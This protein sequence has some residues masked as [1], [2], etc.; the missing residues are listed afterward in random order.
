[1]E[2][3]L[4]AQIEI[5]AALQIIDREIREHAAVKQGLLGELQEKQRLIQERKQNYKIIEE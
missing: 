3:K 5:L 2:K 1:M 4:R